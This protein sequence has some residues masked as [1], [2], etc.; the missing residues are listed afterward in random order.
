MPNKAHKTIYKYKVSVLSPIHIGSGNSFELN[1]NMFYKN[2]SLYLCDEFKL[3]DYFLT[4]NPKLEY[5]EKEKMLLKF[6]EFIKNSKEIPFIRKIENN[7][8]LRNKPLLEH[9]S[10]Q[11]IK[12]NQILS[13]PYIPGSSI[14]GGLR[15]A[16][17]NGIV[18]GKENNKII[19]N[20]TRNSDCQKIFNALDNK[21]F[22]KNNSLNKDRFKPNDEDFINVFKDLYIS[23]S[24]SLKTKVYQS[25]N[26]KKLKDHQDKRKNGNIERCK[27]FLECIIPEQTFEI[28]ITDKNSNKIFE[29][30]DNI[31]TDFYKKWFEEE[32]YYFLDKDNK[33]EKDSKEEKDENKKNEYYNFLNKEQWSIIKEKVEKTK[34][35]FLLNVGRFSGAERKTLN[36]YRRIQ[37]SKAFNKDNKKDTSTTSAR[38]YVLSS[39]KEVTNEKFYTNKLLPFGWLLFEKIN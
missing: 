6:T 34:N 31:C 9:I 10:S 22:F 1:Y 30:L 3:M 15:T 32:D 20:Q 17:L 28:T 23:D 35:G 19:F 38:T 8:I 5:F 7:F 33:K 39:P 36:D 37:N 29:N 16:I 18:P 25:I 4:K 2:N 27:N 12:D 21:K 14:K 11:V 13:L 26:M 24:Q